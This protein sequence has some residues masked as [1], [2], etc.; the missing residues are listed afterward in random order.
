MRP[1]PWVGLTRRWLSVRLTDKRRRP[2]R[3]GPL[4]LSSVSPAPDSLRHQVTEQ[5][6]RIGGLGGDAMGSEPATDVHTVAMEVRRALRVGG[7]IDNLRQVDH[8]QP[9]AV[10]QQV[11]RRQVTVGV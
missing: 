1:L 7:E 9:S 3:A 6:F 2:K 11:E 8:H 10:Y 5:Q 4:R